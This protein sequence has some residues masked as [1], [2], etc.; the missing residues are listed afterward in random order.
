MAQHQPGNSTPS[1]VP[2]WSVLRAPANWRRIDFIS[3][4]HLQ[5]SEITTFELWRNYLQ[6]TQAD[7]IFILG[8]LFEVWVGDDVA[9]P[10]SGLSEPVG[11]EFSCAQALK[12]AAQRHDIFFMH[13]NR[14]FLLGE[15]FANSCGMALLTDP[16]LLEF[17]SERWL[18]SHGDA[19]CLDDTEYMRFR[20]EVRTSA[21]QAQFLSQDLAQR[22]AVARA[23][24]DNSES[25]KRSGVT[26][27]DLDVAAT[28]DWLAATQ[29]HTLIH[30]H[31]HK[32]ADHVLPEGRRRV[33]LSDWDAEA[34]PVR[35]EVLRLSLDGA[36]RPSMQRLTVSQAS[37]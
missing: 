32:P 36:H 16:T 34:Q 17:G 26:Y 35:A 4:L 10:P 8:D 7:A 18:L 13:G 14:D 28:V 24:R 15:T 2:P 1:L 21:W 25:R 12:D 11:F 19:L 22:Q 6:R 30:G 27:A 33:V 5:A 3:D 20:A 31:T 29:S 37:Q 9:H 23:L